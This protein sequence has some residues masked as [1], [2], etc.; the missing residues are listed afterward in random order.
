M[1]KILMVLF[2]N[3]KLKKKIYLWMMVEIVFNEIVGMVN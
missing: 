2:E 1:W 3:W